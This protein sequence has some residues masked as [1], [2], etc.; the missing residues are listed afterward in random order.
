[1]A[2]LKRASGPAGYSGTPLVAKLGLKPG[3][4]AQ[5]VAAPPD[6]GDTIGRMPDGVKLVTRGDLD[7]A[8]VFVHA[9][10]DLK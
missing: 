6:F 10:S 5:L 2:Q 7:F 1:M 4:R 9:R 8:M 3:S